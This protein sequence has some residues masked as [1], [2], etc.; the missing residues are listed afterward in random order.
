MQILTGEFVILSILLFVATRIKVR[1]PTTE[2]ILRN[3]CIYLPPREEQIKS[4]T[5]GS[6]EF[7][8]STARLD[9]NFSRKSNF[10]GEVE[11]LLLLATIT[12]GLCL[13]NWMLTGNEFIKIEHN[14][15]FYLSLLVISLCIG[16]A[17]SQSVKSGLRN[18][19]NIIGFIISLGL[20]FFSAVVLISEHQKILD[21]NFHFSS[22]LL[23]LSVTK[24][25]AQFS[26]DSIEPDYTVFSLVISAVAAV[27]F[28]PYFKYLFKFVLNICMEDM[29]KIN[30][31]GEAD[32]HINLKLQLIYPLL[33]LIFWVK[34]MT[35]N[36]LVPDYMTESSF[37]YLRLAI[38]LSYILLRLFQLRDEVQT[39]LNQAKYIIYGILAE[40]TK[41]NIAKSIEQVAA[42]ARYAWPFA[43]L[44]LCY[45]VYLAFLVI[46]LINKAD[47]SKPY[48]KPISEK[49]SPQIE[50]I[51]YDDEEFTIVTQPAKYGLITPSRTVYYYQEIRDIEA[52]ISALASNRTEAPSS[53]EEVIQKIVEINRE[54]VIP[55]LFYRDLL[56]Y[57]IFLNLW[58]NALSYCFG[59]LYSRRFAN[60]TKSS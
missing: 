16:G 2:R 57:F 24:A 50:P 55:D 20:L 26:D 49:I 38:I 19:D 1:V 42:Y 39:L 25:M 10:F 34:P 58:F 28:F 43:H 17:Y 15:S 60:K 53:A 41:E 12:A 37:E 18:P 6:K 23:S 14:L 45:T 11:F 5:T 52:S 22:K 51:V 8:L 31:E 56:N 54:G 35:K 33:V 29:A 21:F 3:L 27:S 4:Y 40:P 59:L 46:L 9:D 48:P 13:V 47:L 44:S 32:P 36:F 7:S 30:V